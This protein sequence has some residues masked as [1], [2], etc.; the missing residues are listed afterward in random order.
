MITEFSPYIPF[1]ALLIALCGFGVTII[2]NQREIKVEYL[3][4]LEKHETLSESRYLET[5]RRFERIAVSLAKAGVEN[6][7][8]GH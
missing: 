2:H 1:F 7:G 5:L 8:S 4:R 3:E 6:G